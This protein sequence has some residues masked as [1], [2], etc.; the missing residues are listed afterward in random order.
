MFVVLTCI[1]KA[2]SVPLSGSRGSYP[3]HHQKEKEIL[4][5]HGVLKP[6]GER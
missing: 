5:V 4:C 2:V 1:L 3:R 6:A